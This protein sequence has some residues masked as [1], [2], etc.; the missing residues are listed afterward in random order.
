MNNDLISRSALLE[1]VESRLAYLRKVY[2]FNDQYTDGYDAC[3]EHIE[4]AP[5]VD[6][7]EV[8]RC[9]ECK[10]WKPLEHLHLTDNVKVCMLAGY[11]I[12]GNGYCLYVER[13][14]DEDL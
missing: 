5:A 8:I 9:R 2:G 11:A 3:A 10:H 1:I 4:T 7:V 6:A 12:G 14:A 13:K